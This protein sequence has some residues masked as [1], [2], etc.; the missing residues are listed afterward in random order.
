MDNW[1]MVKIGTTQAQRKLFYN[2]NKERQKLIAQGFDPDAAVL[3]KNLN[4]S[5]KQV[6]EMEQRMDGSDVSLDAPVSVDGSPGTSRIELLPA[7]GP[8]IE[9]ILADD[10]IAHLVRDKLAGIAPL[11]S[12]KE[13]YI[14]ENRLLTDEPVTLREIGEKY[15]ITRERVRQIEA[16]LLQKVRDHLFREIKDFSRD[17]IAEQ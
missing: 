12:E 16:R 1:R 15:D 2:L 11:L 7:L 3:S 8:G 5:E 13:A 14:L 4:V 17:W 6:L 10:Q 9:D